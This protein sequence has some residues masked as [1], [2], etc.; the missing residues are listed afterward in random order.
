MKK[1]V[2]AGIEDSQKLGGA[3][4]KSGIFA[5][6]SGMQIQA[7]FEIRAGCQAAMVGKT[8]CIRKIVVNHEV[9]AQAGQ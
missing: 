5:G 2:P 8:V 6:V 7:A 1:I 3:S 4:G 9:H